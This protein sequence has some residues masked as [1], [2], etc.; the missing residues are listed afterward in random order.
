MLLTGGPGTG[1]TFTVRAI[2]DAW[3]AEGKQ[4]LLACPT[5]RAASVLAAAVGAPASTIHRLLEYNPREE[6]FKRDASNPL[7]A[8]AVVIDEVS[9]LDV[10][11]CGALFHA[12]KPGAHILMVGDD[13][14]LPSVGAGA[15]LHDLLR[16][17]R[18]PRVE[19]SAVFRQDPSGDIARNARLIKQGTRPT[20]MH[21]FDS[22]ASLQSAVQSTAALQE[23]PSG[24]VLIT[25]ASEGAALESITTGV[26]DWL[27]GSGY[28]LRNEVQVL[29]PIKAGD[30]GTVV[31]NGRCRVGSTPCHPQ[32]RLRL[33]SRLSLPNSLPN[34]EVGDAVS[35]QFEASRIAIPLA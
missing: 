19:L 14:Q 3:R 16:C 8:D 32:R 26:I 13:D 17:P 28:D 31:L 21:V 4:V 12:L 1:K 27:E 24:T 10:L 5:A 9:M 6:A 23:R 25:A 20:H 15:V 35:V 7:D 22:V 11:L 2:V 34:A 30:A 29:T 33:I 18:I